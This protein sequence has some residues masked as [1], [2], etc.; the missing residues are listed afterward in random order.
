M[1]LGVRVDC[2]YVLEVGDRVKVGISKTPYKRVSTHLANAK[3][4][5]VPTG[6]LW[7]SEPDAQAPLWEDVL[8]VGSDSEYL[9]SA[10][11]DDLVAKAVE[12]GAVIRKRPEELGYVRSEHGSSGARA[13]R[14]EETDL[15]DFGYELFDEVMA[16]IDRC[17]AKNAYRVPVKTVGPEASG[18]VRFRDPDS[19][20]LRTLKVADASALQVKLLRRRS[21]IALARWLVKEASKPPVGKVG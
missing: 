20:K 6:R 12:L 21:V 8:C 14:I 13:P 17:V 11:F 4:H 10:S 9:G 19:E 18:L 16:A 2:L 5:G 7:I 1:T 3:N 15:A